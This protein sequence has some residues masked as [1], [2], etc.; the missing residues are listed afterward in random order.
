MMIQ[1]KLACRGI[2]HMT[3]RRMARAMI[4]ALVGSML[5]ACQTQKAVTITDPP[6]PNAIK[7]FK[8]GFSPGGVGDA[9]TIRLDLFFGNKGTPQ[10]WTVEI[11]TAG[12]VV[13]K[14]EG[15]GS[16]DELPSQIVWDGRTPTGAVWP[17]GEYFAMLNV[18]YDNAYYP[19]KVTWDRFRLVS[20]PPEVSLDAN[21]PSFTPEGQ[22]MAGP[23][24]I[25]IEA[26][27]RMA[28]IAD[29][30]V[31]VRD[32]NGTAVKS[33]A[34][35]KA[36]D[37]ALWDGSV[38]PQG[39]AEPSKS[40][41][42]M[43]EVRDEYGNVG[44]A[45]FPIAVREQVAP[46]ETSLIE[47]ESRGFSPTSGKGDGSIDFS[48]KFGNLDSLRSWRVEIAGSGLTRRT[49]EGDAD[50]APASLSWDGRDNLG[51]LSPEGTY[52][53]ALS[54][55]YGRTFKT[56]LAKTKDFILSTSPPGLRL[57]ATPESFVPSDKGVAS[58]VA[59]LLDAS[60]RLGRIVSWTLD[61]LDPQG[62]SVRAF[63][64]AWPSNQAIWDGQ[65]SSNT[66]VQSGSTYL[67]KA[68]ILDE[69]GNQASSTLTIGV[70]DIPQPS[71]LSVIEPRSAG[72]SPAGTGKPRSID[73]ILVAGNSAQMKG[74][75]V[76]ISQAE[77]GSQRVFSGTAATLKRSLS[78]DGKTDAG[79]I[80]P[81]G[82]Y[83]AVLSMDYG[84]S[85][86]PASVRSP[87]FSLQAAPPDLS[88]TLSP[89]RLTPLA[90]DFAS[91]VSIDLGA[92]SR[93]TEVE[94]WIVSILDP[95]GKT[96]ALYKNVT[97]GASVT[98]NGRTN[99][100]SLAEPSMTYQV[101]AEVRDSF[102]NT[103]FAKALIPVDDLPPVSGMS[104]ITPAA[105]GFSPNGDGTADTIDM[106]LSVPNRE[107]VN[108]WKVVISDSDGGVQKTFSGDRS[109]LKDLITWAGRSDSGS[110]APEG[111]YE[112]EMSIDYG[113][114]YKSVT[115]R[116]RRFVLDST[117]PQA[118]IQI[119]PGVVVPDERGLVAP[120][121]ITLDA[122]S[123]LAQISTWKVSVRE[124][125]GKAFG[126][127]EGAWP[128][129]RIAW[130]G[131]AD[132]GSL[133][134]PGMTY[135]VTAVVS[136]EFGLTDQR[137]SV[138]SV[139]PLPQ[140]TEP[141]AVSA[142]AKGFSPVGNGSIKFALS[143]GNRNLVKNWNLDIERDD[144]TLRMRYAGDGT[145]LPESFS[146]N[147]LLQDGTLAPD[148]FYTATLSLDYG[149]VYAPAAVPSDAFALVATAPT[150]RIVVDPA[151][152][153]PDGS[154]KGDSVSISLEATSRYAKI[155]DWSIGI[156]DPGGNAFAS[157]RGQWPATTLAWNGRNAKNELVESAEDYPIV[158]RVRDEFGNT[159]ELKSAVHV[160]ILIVKM[161][162]GYRIRI[163]SIVFKPFTP[164]YLAVTTDI[165]ERNVST[166]N[167]LAEKLKKFPGYQI[168]LVGHAVMVNWDNPV[169]GKA[170][171]EKELLPLSKARA[172]SIMQALVTRGIESSRM[173]TTG[174]G[175][176]DQVVPDS[177]F[178]N[179]WKNRRVEFFLQK[180]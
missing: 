116:S 144:R 113:A 35:T 122:G 171:Q 50:S 178:P 79:A 86:K 102:G 139:G 131:V 105:N 152:F 175:A 114:I 9:R 90:G 76:T 159:L 170:E 49:F 82:S 172:A 177:D 160:D 65:T 137:N 67:A 38:E 127:F 39:F 158:A 5:I 146:W 169:L 15:R 28:K 66:L 128:P 3:I 155:N 32:N 34:G 43:A 104:A 103:G 53:A 88:L 125:T 132:D 111:A 93:F 167:L 153:S 19:G 29:W 83:Y 72:F 94:S 142:L 164:D 141:S 101:I 37:S 70:R 12:A 143:I 91:P 124:P 36:V 63:N 89:P 7:A 33:F 100:G 119:S 31:I 81:D 22:G 68:T 106:A 133:A 140:A 98:W 99:S 165:A 73:F 166:L 20:S 136:D 145:N 27:S 6:E 54:L 123:A 179:R 138:I 150:G 109:S 115:V 42:A 23:V 147:G 25:G 121:G 118:T 44:K 59:V 14:F 69:F 156:S 174:V 55:D 10:L 11:V 41:T 64:Q 112:A 176:S 97:P 168:K 40:Y 108:S 180:K 77:R 17:E 1:K 126:S 60:P 110:T 161:G 52:S 24:T 130:T 46:T 78:W 71:E 62:K 56:A 163:A 57:R 8:P 48:L 47:T 2:I 148:G 58:P 45:S 13:K 51:A 80:A 135:T 18:S 75:K 151:L 4:L 87:A 107:A 162:D 85:F 96:V 157:F 16:G 61:I 21:P 149:R 95:N 74:W 134:E 30:S 117:P 173:V 154:G 120:A 26:K 84:K 129:K 92:T